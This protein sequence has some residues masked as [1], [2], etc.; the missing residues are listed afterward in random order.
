[1]KSPLALLLCDLFLGR[2]AIDL[3]FLAWS[4]KVK[5]ATWNPAASQLP[6]C[7]VPRATILFVAHEPD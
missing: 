2:L 7:G 5:P 4:D 1:M 3:T 6:G